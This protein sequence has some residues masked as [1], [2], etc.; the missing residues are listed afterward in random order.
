MVTSVLQHQYL[1]F[2]PYTHS[3]CFPTSLFS[4]SAFHQ[5]GA[6]RPGTERESR[7]NIPALRTFGVMAEKY[8]R[9]PVAARRFASNTRADYRKVKASGLQESI[10]YWP[11]SSLSLFSLILHGNRE[12]RPVSVSVP[13]HSA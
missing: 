4:C 8:V 2:R 6:R 10:K 3:L 12:R 9:L 5:V 13:S 7:H 11:T 1:T